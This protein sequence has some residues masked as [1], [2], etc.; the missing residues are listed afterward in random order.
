MS[1]EDIIQRTPLFKKEWAA[2]INRIQEHQHTPSWNSRC[3]DRLSKDD[4]NFTKKFSEQLR[5]RKP[6]TDYPDE[7]ILSWIKKLTNQ[8]WW[9]EE[10]LKGI[11]PLND[12]HSIPFMTRSDL[13]KHLVKIVPHSIP[14]DNIIVNPT[15]GTTGQPIACPSHPRAQGAY[16]P[17]ILFALS[18]NGLD[19]SFTF[20][21]MAAIQ[22]C[23]QQ[24][25]MTYFTVHSYLNGAAFAKINIQNLGDWKTPESPAL[26]IQ[27]MAP[28]FFSG[29]PFSFF[30]AI[31]SKIPYQP[32]ALLSTAMTLDGFLYDAIREYYSCPIVNF[33]SL[34]ETGPLG[35]SCPHD[36]QNF[37]I[38]PT[39]VYIET[40]NNEGFPAKTGEPGEIVVTGGRNPFL[41][42]LRYRTG[43]RA[44]LDFT[45]CS[46]GDPH[47]RLKNL[48][49]RKPVFFLDQNNNLINPIDISRILKNYPIAFHQ[50]KQTSH[51]KIQ[52]LLHF[53]YPQA[54]SLLLEIRN[55]I[56][57]LF[58]NSIDIEV[59]EHTFSPGEKII[60]YINEMNFKEFLT[61]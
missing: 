23:A 56:N 58:H 21:E 40:L 27:D 39:D 1:L 19:H 9:F 10:A 57:L 3:G 20:P 59:I 52:L 7:K 22:L 31:R 60:P 16:D 43:D 36:P 46:C 17:L 34:N 54:P 24:E 49:A 42:L 48:E 8:S 26:F 44:I 55:K 47:P 5:E 15:S 30:E 41:P 61:P 2:T 28:V 12:F 51:K 13:Q 18:R 38:L 6:G 33:Y 35:Y 32:Q 50:M 45:P 4:L 11:D 14:L 37:H 29:D 53:F 25:T